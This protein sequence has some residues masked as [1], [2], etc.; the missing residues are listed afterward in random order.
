[1]VGVDAEPVADR[2]QARPELR[3]RETQTL[4][5]LEH[6]GGRAKR[7]RVVDDRA[8]AET[9]TRDQAYALVVGR[10]G[11]AAAIEPSQAA[12]SAPSKSRSDQ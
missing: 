10:R 3:G 2:V 4:P 8:T 7:S 9:G 1:M 11:A 5:L 12:R 6:L